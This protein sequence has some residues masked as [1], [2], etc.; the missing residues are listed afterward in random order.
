MV[1]VHLLYI[2]QVILYIYFATMKQDVNSANNNLLCTCCT[3][4]YNMLSKFEIHV[5][6]VFAAQ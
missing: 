2:V 5:Y 1:H 3:T 6:D 4:V